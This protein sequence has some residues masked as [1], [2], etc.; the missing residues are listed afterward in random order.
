MFTLLNKSPNS[1]FWLTFIFLLNLSAA[2]SS[3]TSFISF[4]F[5]LNN[6]DIKYENTKRI[7]RDIKDV[8]N[9]TIIVVLASFFIDSIDVDIIA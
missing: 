6:L 9:I 3:V 2:I 1:S 7:K 4:I 8:K 5:L